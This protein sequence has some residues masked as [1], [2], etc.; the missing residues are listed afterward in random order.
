MASALGFAQSLS[1]M[2]VPA[3]VNHCSSAAL[4]AVQEA[5]AAEYRMGPAERDQLA[6]VVQQVLVGV[7]QSSQVISLSWQ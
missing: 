5:P 3:G 7:A 6:G 2:R 4:G 1:P